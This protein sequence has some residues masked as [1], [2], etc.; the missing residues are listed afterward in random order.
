MEA[1]PIVDRERLLR[2]SR[3]SAERA[4]GYF[5]ALADDAQ[6][7]SQRIRDAHAAG[8][9]HALHELVHSL[10][11]MA[12]EVGAPRVA[13]AAAALDTERDPALLPDCVD[14]LS[15]V[16]AELRDALGTL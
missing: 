9:A 3:G 13:A 7:A 8:D 5:R 14:A 15:K 1:L 16:I 10:K 12:L 2:V 6:I 11:G 4:H